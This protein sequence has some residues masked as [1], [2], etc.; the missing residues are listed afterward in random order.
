MKYYGLTDIGKRRATNQ[1]YF[2]IEQVGSCLIATVCD[3]M[4]GA[5]G[6]SYASEN[7]CNIFMS[8]NEN[9]LADVTDIDS[10]PKILHKSIDKANSYIY[11]T[12][13]KDKSL[14]GMGTTIVSSVIIDNCLFTLN[15]GDSSIYHF[16]GEKIKK[17]TKDHSYV[18]ALLDAG[19][20]S[21][22]EFKHHPS[23]H[24]LTR[25]LGVEQNV[26][27]D[28]TMYP[29]NSGQLLMCSDGFSNY[30]DSERYLKKTLTSN[31]SIEEKTRLLIDY[32]N[33]KGGVDNITVVL[34]EF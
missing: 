27:A 19:D 9:S 23:K 12:S 34:I 22:E 26:D 2:K 13:L 17:L 10:I 6:G 3:G 8:E 16:D 29:I 7:A 33:K 24:I 25:V 28:I 4:G 15:I 32:A 14:S 1:D 31:K 18:Q 5:N 20:I 11:K 30:L 21:P